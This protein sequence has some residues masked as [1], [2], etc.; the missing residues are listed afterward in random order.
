[1]GHPR[2]AIPGIR[3]PAGRIGLIEASATLSIGSGNFATTDRH[4]AASVYVT[5][6]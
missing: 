4:L 6:Q 1:M 2:P 5:E 3:P